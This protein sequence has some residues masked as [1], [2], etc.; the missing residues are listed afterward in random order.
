MGKHANDRYLDI[1]T[2]S[3]ECIGHLYD[4]FPKLSTSRACNNILLRS[5]ELADSAFIQVQGIH[6]NLFRRR[7]NPLAKRHI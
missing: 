5:S 2:K 6:N 4:D 3:R 7:C 1:L